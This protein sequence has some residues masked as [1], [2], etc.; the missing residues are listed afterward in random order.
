MYPEEKEILLQAGLTAEVTGCYHAD[1]S[2]KP[3]DASDPI[4]HDT[5]TVLQLFIPDKRVERDE[6]RRKFDYIMPI[7]LLSI[8]YLLY[9]YAYILSI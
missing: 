9:S 6:K 7:I 3:I 8:Y 5:L 1:R 4:R 2:G